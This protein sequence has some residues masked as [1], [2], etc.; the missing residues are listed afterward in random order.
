MSRSTK[1]V[2]LSLLLLSVLGATATCAQEYIVMGTPKVNIRTGPSTEHF[3]IGRAEK[4]DIFRVVASEGHWVEI[5]M[6]S[7]D[8]RYVFAA[9]YVY[10]LTKSDLLPGHRMRLPD[11]EESRDAIRRDIQA[12]MARAAREAEEVI[13]ASVDADRNETFR[14]IMEDQI[15]LEVLHVHGF[16]PALYSDLMHGDQP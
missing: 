13:P 1:S 11:S 7:G 4:G 16:Q 5:M 14:K 9:E 3:I 10:P 2:V 15:I 6:F 12:A 8:H